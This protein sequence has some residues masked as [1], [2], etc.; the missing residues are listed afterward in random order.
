MLRSS[1]V[2]DRLI[3]FTILSLV[4]LIT[5][6]SNVYPLGLHVIL[7]TEIYPSKQYCQ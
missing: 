2:Q 7:F 1:V 5:V 4:A 6:R 3:R